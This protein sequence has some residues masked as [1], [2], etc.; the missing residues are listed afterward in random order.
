LH[1]AIDGTLANLTGPCAKSPLRSKRL[2][3]LLRFAPGVA[4]GGLA[5]AI[6]T[7]L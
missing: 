5:R 1:C 3:P 6:A 7:A 4:T 2:P